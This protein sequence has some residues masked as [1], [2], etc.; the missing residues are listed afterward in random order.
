[1]KRGAPLKRT[2]FKPQPRKPLKAR[3]GF[4]IK[5]SVL[6]KISKDPTAQSKVRIQALVREIVIKR[7]KGCILRLKR[8]CGG[9]VGYAVLQ[10][11]HLIT[12]ANSATYGDTRL[13]VCVCTRCHGWKSLGSNRNKKEYDTLVRSLLPPER[14]AL[15]DMAEADSHRTFKADWSLVEVA[16]LRELATLQ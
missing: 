12:R 14:V 11:D 9:D 13:I 8:F 4:A 1:M 15:W 3:K 10:A 2:P 7:D 6:R 16:L 5:K